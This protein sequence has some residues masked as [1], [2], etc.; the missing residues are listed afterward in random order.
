MSLGV[1][2]GQEWR[3]PFGSIT[4]KVLRVQKNGTEA[5]LEVVD[6]VPGEAAPEVGDISVGL[7]ESLE[8]MWVREVGALP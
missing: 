7:C 5:V 1:E 3:T 4:C 6:A 2:A 8:E